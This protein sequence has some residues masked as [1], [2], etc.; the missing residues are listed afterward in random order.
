MIPRSDSPGPPRNSPPHRTV[1]SKIR[2]ITIEGEHLLGGELDKAARRLCVLPI[3]T[4]FI[5]A[6]NAS[7]DSRL[8]SLQRVCVTERTNSFRAANRPS[9]SD[10]RSACRGAAVRGRLAGG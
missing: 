2:I 7:D 6:K 8:V 10:C 3:A 5:N 4:S 1:K 9:R